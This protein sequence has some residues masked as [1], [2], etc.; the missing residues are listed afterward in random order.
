MSEVTLYIYPTSPYAAKVAAVLHYKH[1]PFKVV[2]VDPISKK[3]LAFTQK[4]IVPTIKIDDEWLQDSTPICL[5]LEERFVGPTIL[6]ENAEQKAHIIKLDQWVSNSVLP[7]SF[8]GLIHWDGN[9]FTWLA[10]RWR[11]CEVFH[12]SKPLPLILRMFY[13][14]LVQ[15][16]GF[17]RAHAKLTSWDEPLY[18]MRKR[19]LNEFLEHLGNG[20]FLGGYHSPS[21]AD[22]ALFPAMSL[23]WLVG[24]K[25]KNIFIENEKLQQ[26]LKNVAAKLPQH[27]HLIS[28]KCIKSNL[29]QHVF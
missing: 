6:G 17:I 24:L 25:Q 16:T 10:D 22:F 3:E 1:I 4:P 7:A 19:L 15:R 5:L 27:P 14:W 2:H 28:E 9:Y 13:P 11:Y 26:W 18:K 12:Q 8:R 21:L 23:P 29:L 20:P